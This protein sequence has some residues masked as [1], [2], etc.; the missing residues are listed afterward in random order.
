MEGL[1]GKVVLVVDDDARNLY[2]MATVL[3]RYQIRAPIVFA[4]MAIAAP[5]SAEELHLPEPI[6]PE[7][8]VITEQG[9][10]PLYYRKSPRIVLPTFRSGFGLQV[11]VPTGD[12]TAKVAFTLNAYIGATIRFGRGASTGLLTEAGYSYVGFSEHLASVGI[13][14][15]HGLGR[16]PAPPGESQPIG[17]RRLAIVPHVLVGKAYGG[18]AVGARTSVILG[19]WIY[20]FELAHQVLVVG[21]RQIHEV[22]TTF[23]AIMPMGED[24]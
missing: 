22:H 9:P 6:A 8:R 23:T 21:S 16:A 2:T 1:A 19:Y 12:I 24:E 20:G 4:M 5:S 7:P 13:G 3:E 10:S 11:R 15:L 18:L 14:V 17:R